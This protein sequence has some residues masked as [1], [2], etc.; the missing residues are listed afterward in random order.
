MQSFYLVILGIF[1]NFI[2]SSLAQKL[3]QFEDQREIQLGHRRLK[4]K[5]NIQ[6]SETY[7]IL[8]VFL[9]VIVATFIQV[10]IFMFLHRWRDQNLRRRQHFA[11]VDITNNLKKCLIDKNELRSESDDDGDCPICLIDLSHISQAQNSNSKNNKKDGIKYLKIWPLFQNDDRNDIETDNECQIEQKKEL[12]NQH[13][14]I[15]QNKEGTQVCLLPCGHPY[16]YQ[17][18]E[19]WTLVSGRRVTCPMCKTS[20]VSMIGEE[21]KEDKCEEVHTTPE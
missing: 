4:F 9:L 20:L 6:Q 7:L 5:E 3:H 16:H 13:G 2:I 14:V 12:K 10:C 11:V 18:I 8:I 21:D 15:V 19:T 1:L 17:C